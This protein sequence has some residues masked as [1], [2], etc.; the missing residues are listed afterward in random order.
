[1]YESKQEAPISTKAFMMRCFWHIAAAFLISFI[2]IVIGALGHMYFESIH[3]H[4]ALLNSSMIMGGMGTAFHPES[5]GGK[6]F[7][8][9]Y[10][11]F[12]GVLF[13]ALIGVVAAPLIHRIVHKMH[14][15]DDEETD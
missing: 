2:T 8:A 3:F 9:F 1:M 14:L 12:V 11:L 4:D 6:L 15:D 7:F 5:Y 10:G 13:A